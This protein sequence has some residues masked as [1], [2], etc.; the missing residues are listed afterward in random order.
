MKNEMGKDLGFALIFVD[1]II[2]LFN[3][4]NGMF[5]LN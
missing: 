3:K 1:I 2:R 5:I 4:K